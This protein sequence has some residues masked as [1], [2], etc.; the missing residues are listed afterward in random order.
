MRQPEKQSRAR[1][2]RRRG[3][4][5]LRKGTP[6]EGAIHYRKLASDFDCVL[7]LPLHSTVHG[8]F[9]KR[10]MSTRLRHSCAI[11]PSL[12]QVGTPGRPNSSRYNGEVKPSPRCARLLRWAGH[13]LAQ[14]SPEQSNLGL[15]REAEFDTARGHPTS[16]I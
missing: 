16:L 11:N 3:H 5:V 8:R 10:K 12:L 1:H 14:A 15:Y 2:T 9:E 4:R 6:S 13:P 7:Q